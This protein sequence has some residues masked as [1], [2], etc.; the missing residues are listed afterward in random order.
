MERLKTW[1]ASLSRNGKT[2]LWATALIASIMV[3]STAASPSQTSQQKPTTPIN[4]ESLAE[5]KTITETVPLA[6]TI[7]TI[8]DPDLESGKTTLRTAGVNGTKTLTYEIT[9][10]N[11]T[12]TDKKL[13][14][15]EVTVSPVHQVIAVGTKTVQP[16]P[17][18]PD[19][20]CNPNY[21]GCVPV[22]S[23]VDCAAGGGNGP[24]YLSQTVTVLGSD[25]YGLD[26]DG[27]GLACE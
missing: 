11:G 19:P 1:Y 25:V 20:A 12:Q 24:A 5:K 23:D 3:V 10:A 27:D 14:K 9:Y 8:N 17:A 7:T 16:P 6:Y 2:F 18:Q 13:I 26:R 22:A 4:T 21:S 15:E